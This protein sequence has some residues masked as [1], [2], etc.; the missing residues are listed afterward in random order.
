VQR[1]AIERD[2]IRSALISAVSH[3][4][5]NDLHLEAPPFLTPMPLHRVVEVLRRTRDPA[6]R[7]LA[8]CWLLDNPQ[9]ADQ[10][11][12]YAAALLGPGTTDLDFGAR[13]GSLSFD[14]TCELTETRFT[15]AY[16]TFHD[17]DVSRRNHKLNVWLD[18][19][20]LVT[21]VEASVEVN[22][23]AKDFEKLADPREWE[24]RA[25]L[26]FKVSKLCDLVDGRFETRPDQKVNKPYQQLLLEH[27]SFGLSSGFP[28]DSINVLHVNCNPT[29]KSPTFNVLLHT[30]L[31][32]RFGLSFALGGLDVDGGE[33]RVTET[34][35]GDGVWTELFGS[36]QAR[37]TEREVLGVPAGLELNYFA[38]FWL[39]AFM[40][41]LV[42]EGAAV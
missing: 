32:T 19:S 13:P 29:S 1:A 14:G 41:L 6:A 3:A 42:F 20:S 8:G 22:R 2:E 25:S 31:E 28:L 39:A 21:H 12:P 18:L 37:F 38:P 34:A 24:T 35:D 4:H 33:F 17:Q 15:H 27:V 36:K 10:L 26:F 23:P 7:V 5:Q 16:A 40:T 11:V 9:R 30:C